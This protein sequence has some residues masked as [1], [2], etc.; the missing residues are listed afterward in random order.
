M[1]ERSPPW[2]AG[3]LLQY[4][5]R[6]GRDEARQELAVLR[7]HARHLEDHVA[8]LQ[9]SRV[10]PLFTQH[11]VVPGDEVSPTSRHLRASLPVLALSL[12]QRFRCRF[13]FASTVAEE[14]VFL[15]RVLDRHCLK[16]WDIPGPQYV[17]KQHRLMNKCTL[18]TWQQLTLTPAQA[19]GDAR[20]AADGA[21]A[22]AKHRG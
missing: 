7:G 19:G 21:C 18:L 14:A 1:L 2:Q 13:T 4:P 12:T 16:T 15:R 17:C 20:R 10:R 8:A 11:E 6:L 9:H 3:N 22:A 5:Q